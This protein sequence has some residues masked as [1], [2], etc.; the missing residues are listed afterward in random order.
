MLRA[1]LNLGAAAV[2]GLEVESTWFITDQWDLRGSLTYQKTEYE[3]FCDPNGVSQIGLDP[4]FTVGDGSGAIFNCVDVRGN[5]FQRQP[6][7][8]YNLALTYRNQLA[9]TNWDWVGRLDWRSVGEQ[10]NDNVN[11]MKLPETQSLNASVNFRNQNWDI[12]L[13]G[14]NL[15]DND[16]PRIVQ[17]GTDNN[18]A[19]EN[20]NFNLLPRDPREFGITLSYGF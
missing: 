7:L 9:N 4:D 20:Q 16:S 15:T 12:R 2:S 14:R 10:W 5:S 18:K 1:Q 19:P 13:W 8:S 6:E 3:E 17:T 11:L